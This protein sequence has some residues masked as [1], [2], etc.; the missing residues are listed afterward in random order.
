MENLLGLVIRMQNW[1]FNCIKPKL[2]GKIKETNIM[3]F[4]H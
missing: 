1:L 3:N 4:K 2:R